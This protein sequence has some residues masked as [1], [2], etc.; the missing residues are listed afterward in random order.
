MAS[1]AFVNSGLNSALTYIRGNMEPNM[2]EECNYYFKNVI[3]DYSQQYYEVVNAST[4]KSVLFRCQMEIKM[5]G[6]MLFRQSPY[7]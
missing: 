2:P 1:T 7:I 5:K 4:W 3:L 6:S